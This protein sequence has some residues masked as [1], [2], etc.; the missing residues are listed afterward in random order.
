MRITFPLIAA[1]VMVA[2]SATAAERSGFYVGGDV[3]Q[4]NWNISQSEAN[5]FA[6]DLAGGLGNLGVVDVTSTSN[7]LHDKGTTY[8]FFVGYQILPWLATEVAWMD[9]GNT[10]INASGTYTFRAVTET[11]PTGGAYYAKPKFE[12]QGMALSVLPMLPFMDVFNVYARLG[13]YWG[14]NKLSGNFQAQD[15]NANGTPNGNPYYANRSDTNNT[16]KFLW[17]VGAS[18]TWDQRVSFRVEY[19]GIQNVIDSNGPYGNNKTSVGRL[20]AGVLYRFGHVAEAAPVAAAP[21]AAVAAAPVAAKCVDSDGD[22]VCDS[23][24]RCPNTPKGDRVGPN[25]CSCDVTIRTHFAFDSAELTA[26]DKATLDKVAGR[27]QELEFVS[28]VANG[29]TDNVGKA[30]YNQKLSER[31][32]QAVVDYLAAKGVGAG[33]IKAVGYGETKPIADNSTEE[34]RAANRRVTIH[35]TDCGPAY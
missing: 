11:G 22:G 24:D 23:V 15:T 25:G 30:D 14:N 21:V 3:G 5:N 10:T 28:G 2:T 12:S 26:E 32:A 4:S 29:H 17:G 9:L 27:L 33:R 20:T 34:G 1:A 13:V 7:N 35:R 19:D 31:R 16:S 6:A 8:S 18:Y